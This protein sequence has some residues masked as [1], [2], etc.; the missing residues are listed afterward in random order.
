MPLT[1]SV[2]LLDACAT[3]DD[4]LRRLVYVAEG[5]VARVAQPRK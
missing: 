1:R 5:I 4:P 2:R 3:G